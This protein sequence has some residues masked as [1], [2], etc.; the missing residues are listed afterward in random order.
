[1]KI[2][3]TKRIFFVL[4]F[5]VNI[6]HVILGLDTLRLTFILFTPNRKPRF[7]V[8]GFTICRTC[9]YEIK[10]DVFLRVQFFSVEAIGPFELCHPVKKTNITTNLLK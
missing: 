10:I 4:R 2:N 9:K 5:F 3:L 7:A 6:V 1:M 8:S